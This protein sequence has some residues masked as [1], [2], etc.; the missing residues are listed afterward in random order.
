MEDSVFKTVSLNGFGCG[1]VFRGSPWASSYE[2]LRQRPTCVPTADKGPYLEEAKALL[3][4]AG[5]GDGLDLS[6][7]Y[8]V[9]GHYAV[10]GPLIAQLLSE[11][12]I[13][14]EQKPREGPVA[15]QS[16]QDGNFDLAVSYAVFPFGDPSS[17]MRA[18]Y[19]CGST[20]N[21]GGFCSEEVDA[22]LDKIDNELDASKRKEYVNELDLLLEEQVPFRYRRMGRVR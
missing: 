16:I 19:G 10:W 22:L 18:W 5:Y 14:V 15:I 17:Y 20:E 4:E 12:G 9:E 8:S 3:E 1:Y 13:N 7:T 6:I 21:Y 11:Q 2:D